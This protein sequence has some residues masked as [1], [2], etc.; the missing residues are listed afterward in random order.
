LLLYP[1]SATGA[2]NERSAMKI[3]NLFAKGLVITAV[4]STLAIGAGVAG[5]SASDGHRERITSDSDHERESE[6]DGDEDDH[7]KND[8]DKNEAEDDDHDGGCHHGSDQDVPSTTTPVISVPVGDLP[9]DSTPDTTAPDTTTPDTTVVSFESPAVARVI[10]ASAAPNDSSLTNPQVVTETSPVSAPE[11]TREVTEAPAT[12]TNDATLEIAGNQIAGNE[13]ATAT[14]GRL[15]MTGMSSLVLLGLA[16][17]LLVAGWL[18][19]AGR[20]KRNDVA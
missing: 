15:P 17:S 5:A 20:R 9:V 6:H 8:H 10:P 3:N 19:I 12:T 11:V 14:S 16:T 1:D 2:D 18:V 13:T 7:D 4:A